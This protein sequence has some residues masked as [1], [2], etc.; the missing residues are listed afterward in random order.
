MEIQL[1]VIIV[2]YNGIQFLENCLISLQEKLKMINHEVVVIDNNSA[3]N[4]CPYIKKNF[5][6]VKLIESKINHGF[7]KGNNEAVKYAKGKYV[8]L[9]NNDT[10]LLDDISPAIEL[11]EKDPSIGVVGINMLDKNKNYLPAAGV[12][13]N[14]L[15]MLRFKKLYDS[16]KEFITGNFKKDRYKVGW[17]AGSF[18]LLKKETYNQINGFDEDYFMYV[19]DVDFSKK[20]DN[21]GKSRVFIPSLQYIH[22]VGFNKKKNLQLVKGYKIYLKKHFQGLYYLLMFLALSISKSVKA[23]RLKLI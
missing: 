9:F 22:F 17:L 21:I 12:F 6:D 2:N 15:N 1:S 11:L 13:P 20:I 19:E 8:L 14:I 3:D 16:R 4:S 18:L 5:P 10:I 7:G 23:F